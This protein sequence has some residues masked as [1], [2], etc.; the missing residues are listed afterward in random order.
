MWRWLL[1]FLNLDQ[2]PL[3]IVTTQHSS[4]ILSTQNFLWWWFLSL[5]NLYQHP[6]NIVP[7][8]HFI[9]IVPNHNLFWWLAF[10]HNQITSTYCQHYP[11]STIYQHCAHSK[12][13]V[14]IGFLAHLDHINMLSTFCPLTFFN[15][16]KI[17]IP[18]T[19]LPQT[20]NI[21][22]MVNMKISSGAG[23][24]V[25]RLLTGCGIYVDFVP[26]NYPHFLGPTIV[27]QHLH[28]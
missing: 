16:F 9:N 25:G 13:V 28:F 21:C 20:S 18:S 4:H 23:M 11:H 2:H 7:T 6:L 5:L 10:W 26:I 15:N 24:L 1:S 22:P 14:L 19:S 8:Q 27:Q 12:F 3:N 17:N